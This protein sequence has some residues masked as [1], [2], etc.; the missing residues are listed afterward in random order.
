MADQAPNLRDFMGRR[1][2][3]NGI[4]CQVVEV[5][6]EQTILVL[7]PA[8]DAM[9]IQTNQYGEPLRRAP[10]RFSVPIFDGKHWHPEMIALG[11][12]EG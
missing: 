4:A 5:L 8:D 2:H 7:A 10:V 3:Y 11:L 6:E 9:Q 12:I 1:V